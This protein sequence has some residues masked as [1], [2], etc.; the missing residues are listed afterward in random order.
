M[1]L[2]YIPL[3][4]TQR[5]IYNVPLGLERFKIYIKTILGSSE[6]DIELAPLAAVNPM[7]KD[8]A[9]VY[10][11]KLIALG[12]DEVARAALVEF[13][14][15]IHTLED[16][17]IKASIVVCD[18]LKGGWT[19]RYLDEAKYILEFSKTNFLKRPW[20]AIPCWTSEDIS[21]GQL[22]KNTLAA[23]YRLA[24]MFWHKA[25]TLKEIMVQEGYALVFAEDSR[26]LGQEDL[27]YTRGVIEPYLETTLFPI[28]FACLYGDEIARSVG[29]QPLGLSHRAGFALALDDAEKS[30]RIPEEIFL[31][32]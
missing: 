21:G 17:N 31:T 18:D 7:A 25:I 24:Y 22:R 10:L 16:F 6:A 1:P 14:S 5:E 4:T 12:A 26:W 28:Q 29:Y 11:E 23:L 3:L 32:L 15:R 8:H 2:E 9:K 30:N 19:N 20:L 27:E 13:N